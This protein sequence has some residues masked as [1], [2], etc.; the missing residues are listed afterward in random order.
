MGLEVLVCRRPCRRPV[1]GSGDFGLDGDTLPS[2]KV[3]GRG[4]S[5]GGG[6]GDGGGG[7]GGSG[8]LTMVISS[9]PAKWK[10][11]EET[12]IFHNLFLF[13]V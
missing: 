9:F 6:G 4:N 7:G 8:S 13:G 1:R 11:K 12:S 10:N 3:S 2:L 5:G